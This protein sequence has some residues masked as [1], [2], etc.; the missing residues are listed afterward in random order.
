[1]KRGGKVCLVSWSLLI[2][3]ILGGTS[4]GSIIPIWYVIPMLIIAPVLGFVGIFALLVA[5]GKALSDLLDRG[6]DWI[7]EE[8]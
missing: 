4:F 5:Y 7:S 1:M 2:L 3:V 8:K 6:F